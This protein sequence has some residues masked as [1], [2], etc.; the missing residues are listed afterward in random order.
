MEMKTG[1]IA[2]ATARKNEFDGLL[3]AK[4]AFLGI[5]QIALALTLG[6]AEFYHL[7]G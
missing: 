1:G 4:I 5:S 3:L 6:V 7:I 2:V